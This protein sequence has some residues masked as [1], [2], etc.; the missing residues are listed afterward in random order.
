MAALAPTAIR[1]PVVVSSFLDRVV[2]RAATSRHLDHLAM[3][4]LLRANELFGL[5]LGIRLAKLRDS[6]DRLAEVFVAAEGGA[7]QTHLFAEAADI[8]RERWDRLPERRR[9]HYRPVQRYRI[10]RIRH[11]L[12]LSAADT[13][14]WF[15]VSSDTILRWE[16]EVTSAQSGQSGSESASL[17]RAYSARSPIRRCRAFS[18]SVHSPRRLRRPGKDRPCPRPSRMDPLQENRRT[19]SG[20]E[21]PSS[22]A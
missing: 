13:A 6:G 10:L 8:L 21:A 22:L 7:V 16:R 18:R 14:R 2:L 4:A 20:G 1:R 3:R 19:H 11:L 9:P 15:R 12:G 17:V 5:A